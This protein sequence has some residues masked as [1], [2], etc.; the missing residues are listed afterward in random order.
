MSKMFVRTGWWISP[1]LAARFRTSS[2]WIRQT[3]PPSKTFWE[4]SN[5]IASSFTTTSVSLDWNSVFNGEIPLWVVSITFCEGKSREC[6][7]V[8]REGCLGMEKWKSLKRIG[9]GS[10][11]AMWIRTGRIPSGPQ[12]CNALA[13]FA[14]VIMP[15]TSNDGE[16]NVFEVNMR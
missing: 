3:L 2:L 16:D 14:T 15:V 8:W 10:G 9:G 12:I 1:A 11:P 6:L 7:S 5:Y 13:K 4:V